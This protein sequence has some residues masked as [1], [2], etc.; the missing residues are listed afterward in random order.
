MAK[1]KS[2]SKTRWTTGGGISKPTKV[3]LGEKIGRGIY[4]CEAVTRSRGVYITQVA[5]E[6]LK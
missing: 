5:E 2:N 3:V 6:D 4:L 1:S